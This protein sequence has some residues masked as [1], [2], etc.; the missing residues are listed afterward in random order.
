M[1]TTLNIDE[2]SLSTAARLTGVS[3]KTELVRLGLEALI[4]RNPPKSLPLSA[5]AIA[6]PRRLPVAGLGE[7]RTLM[8]VVETS[9]WNDQHLSHAACRR[10]FGQVPD[11]PSAANMSW[12]PTSPAHKLS[13]DR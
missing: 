13:H 12:Q 10:R 9:V 5:A 6:G 8:S 4:A 2:K 7:W 1:R 11:D 3:K